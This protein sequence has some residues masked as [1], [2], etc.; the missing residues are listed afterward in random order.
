ME[1]KW[2]TCIRATITVV[3]MYA[4]INYW[5]GF[6]NFATGV[7]HSVM[8]LIIG[9]IMA[10][11]VNILMSFYESIPQKLGWQGTKKKKSLKR[12]VSMILAYLSIVIIVVLIFRMI[13]PELIGCIN[14][15]ID[16]MPH[17][18]DSAVKWLETRVD[19]NS[20]LQIDIGGLL[21]N[22]GFDIRET[23]FQYICYMGRKNSLIS[24]KDFLEDI[25]QTG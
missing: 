11:A 5:S 10:Y 3:I 9:C 25:C 14:I 24:L 15:L 4:L 7:L 18:I 16:K 21:N 20:L 6:A 13:I 17:A 1:L 12:P 23:V 2:K 19:I 22:N 8:P